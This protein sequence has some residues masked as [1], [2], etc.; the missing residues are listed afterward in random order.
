MARFYVK[1]STLP[2][3]EVC[4]FLNSST[5]NGHAQTIYVVPFDGSQDDLAGRLAKLLPQ[6]V[7]VAV[8]RIPN[9]SEDRPGNAGGPV[10]EPENTLL[11]ELNG[12]ACGVSAFFTRGLMRQIAS[13]SDAIFRTRRRIAAGTQEQRNC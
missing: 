8:E 9:I 3:D 12:I 1:F 13:A 6:D 5:G 2:P 11:E 10:I 4:V 7:T